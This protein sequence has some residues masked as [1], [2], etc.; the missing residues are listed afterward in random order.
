MKIPKIIHQ[1]YDCPSGVPDTLLMLS[2]TWKTKHPA[3]EYCFWNHESIQSFL[4]DHCSQFIPTYNS[5]QCDK[6]RWE[7]LRY[8][9][10]YH[11]GGLYVDMDC[12]CLEP[13]DSL[14]KNRLCCLGLEPTENADRLGKKKLI[15]NAMPAAV[16]RHPFFE[17]F[18]GMTGKAERNRVRFNTVITDAENNTQRI[19][20]GICFIGNAFNVLFFLQTFLLTLYFHYTGRY[21]TG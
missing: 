3:W 16:P 4:Q 15:G 9:I 5:Y 13:V 12:E 1:I 18:V 6:Q 17:Q 8:L 7:L 10:L 14:L 19:Q 20:Y 11:I 2:E 21:L